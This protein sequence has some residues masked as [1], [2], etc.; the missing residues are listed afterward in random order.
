MHGIVMQNL[1]LLNLLFQGL[2]GFVVTVGFAV[3]FN[4]PRRVLPWTGLVG[5]V[6]YLLRYVMRQLGSSNEMATAAG[7]LAIGLIGYWQAVRFNL[8]RLLFTVVGIISMIPG[9]PAYEVMLYFSAGD[10]QAGLNNLVKVGLQTGAIALGLGT[11]RLLTE[12]DWLRSD[13]KD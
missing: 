7:S 4:V 5:A 8:P 3:L 13:A 1:S 9:I 2:L 12:T 10:I 11:A 6:G